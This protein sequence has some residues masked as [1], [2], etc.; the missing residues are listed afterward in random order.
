MKLNILAISLFVVTAGVI[1]FYPMYQ[2]GNAHVN[3]PTQATSVDTK[4]ANK[5]DLVF[6]LDTTG[7]MGGMIEAAKEKIWSIATNMA[8]AKSAPEIRIG[9]VA[10]RDR[11]DAYVTTMIDLSNDLDSV[12]AKLMDFTADGGGDT[13]ESVNQALHEAVTKMSWSQSSNAYKVI[14]VVGDAPAQ[15]NYHNDVKYPAS[16]KMAKAKGI[17]VNT[18]QCG[19]DANTLTQWK[20]MAS[21]SEGQFFNVAQNGNAVAMKTPFDE[22]L[23][24]LSK[25]LDSTR[26]YYG[27]P[28]VL[29]EK[30][31]KMAAT[32]KMHKRA[33][34][35]SR[36]RRATFNGSASGKVNAIG[37]ND[38]V[39]DIATGRADLSSIAPKE[40][41]KPMQ[42]M[43]PKEKQRLIAD[44]KEKRSKLKSNISVLAKKR[45]EYIKKEMEK[46]GGAKDSLDD[47][48]VGALRM[49]AKEK[50]IDYDGKSVAY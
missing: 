27:T 46:K 12:Y 32:S 22:Q 9:L 21:L 30:H 42:A 23:A 33:S 47:Q 45:D 29:A 8:Q 13:P 14:F 18:I 31:S 17:V 2:Q 5:I 25:D 24:T 48:L 19:Q 4:Q 28:E 40:L 39:E 11:G 41:P 3:I 6:A 15:M 7:S 10:F 49:Q 20:Q 44:T 16:I 34:V 36:A 50:G 43:S 26:L 1:G 35:E 38:L 37:E